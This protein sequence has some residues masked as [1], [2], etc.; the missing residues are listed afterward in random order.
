[1]SALVVGLK[2]W[3]APPEARMTPLA[4]NSSIEPSRML[5]AIAPQHS[6]VVVLQSAVTNHSS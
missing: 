2:H 1:M 5:R 4:A 6:P 3:P